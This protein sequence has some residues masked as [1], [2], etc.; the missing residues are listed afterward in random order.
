[1]KKFWLL[2][3]PIVLISG[4]LGAG[5]S[6]TDSAFECA[7]QAF[8]LECVNTCSVVSPDCACRDHSILVKRQITTDPTFELAMSNFQQRQYLMN[9]LDM[10]AFS[11]KPF[12]QHS[13][14][15]C[16]LG[17]YFLP[18]CKNCIS[19]QENGSGDV[20]PLWLQ[21]ISSLT[22]QYSSMVFLRPK[23]T[24][25]GMV[26]NFY[27]DLGDLIEGLWIS[28]NTTFM[29]V[30]TNLV[31]TEEGLQDNGVIPCLQT[32]QQM[33]TNCQWDYNKFLCGN[34]SRFGMDDVQIKVG[35]DALD[36]NLGHLGLYVVGTIPTGTR[37]RNYSVFEPLVGSRNGSL[38]FGVNTDVKYECCQDNI[39]SWMFD[40]KY[41][42]VFPSCTIRS[43]DLTANGDWSRYLLVTTQTNPTVPLPGINF[44]TLPARVTPRSTIDM[45]TGFHYELCDWEFEVG[46][47]FWWKQSE[48]I[49]LQGC[50]LS[51]LGIFDLQGSATGSPVSAS[52]ATISQTV[53]SASLGHT[54]LVAS[55]STFKPITTAQLNLCSG[56]QPSAFTNKLYASVGYQ[57]DCGLLGV[58]GSY[59]FAK[60]STTLENWALWLT[61]SVQFD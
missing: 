52:R 60:R 61:A 38:G 58:N 22:K 17:K 50:V 24:Q 19:F 25:W 45:W 36:R 51:G 39:F 23:M 6:L 56:A 13:N 44:L 8:L 42:Y 11:F 32:A 1:M 47:T 7:Y 4:T 46:Y 18:G 55:D 15:K 10:Y 41:R 53:A 59:E 57:F 35:Y 16:E 14:N 9:C 40:F 5:S 3:L 27:G 2:F 34:Q 12:Y 31:L 26:V 30:T 28:I 37:P 43:F 48:K 49:K 33:L 21:G 54:N 20:D 29:N